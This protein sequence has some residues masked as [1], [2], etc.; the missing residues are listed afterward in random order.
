MKAKRR[1]DLQK[2]EL[3]VV[4]ER[5]WEAIAPYRNVVL[6]GVIVV[7]GAGIIYRVTRAIRQQSDAE[8][9]R[10]LFLASS[11]RDPATVSKQLKRVAADH[12]DSE[13]GL[14][15]AVLA[16]DHQL[17]RGLTLLFSDRELANT[18]L[19]DAQDQY[20]YVLDELGESGGHHLLRIRAL[21]G[22]AQVY[23]ARSQVEDAIKT[24]GKVV[25]IAEGIWDEVARARLKRLEDRRMQRWYFWFARQE[26]P[27]PR[28]AEPTASPPA[29]LPGTD[30][31]PSDP[32]FGLKKADASAAGP[33][34]EMEK[35]Q[36]PDGSAKAP[37]KS[38]SE[39][40]AN[41][42]PPQA[43][44]KSP[45]KKSEKTSEKSPNKASAR[46]PEKAPEKA[47][48]KGAGKTSGKTSGVKADKSAPS[49]S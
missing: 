42:V 17:E 15:A 22:L 28:S 33:S 41:K 21:F 20:Q 25:D 44:D 49:G 3:A 19:R 30:A 8:T 27:P 5:W 18:A 23:E 4:L 14:W 43:P 40:N 1:H 35:P 46:A 16:G 26:P 9:W 29:A 39:P 13:A 7:L 38:A 6:I 11:S 37:G 32:D 2:N 12:R 48:A 31:L 47:P 10:S 36:T 34:K 24:Y 45:K